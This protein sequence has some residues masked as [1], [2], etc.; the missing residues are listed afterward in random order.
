MALHNVDKN[1]QDRSSPNPNTHDTSYTTG[2]PII[3]V[4]RPAHGIVSANYQPPG[5]NPSDQAALK[6]A[7]KRMV[8]SGTVA[9][10]N[11]GSTVTVTTIAHGLG[12]AP[13]AEG[14]I[15]NASAT[16]IGGLVN[17]PLPTF[18]VAHI[19]AVTPKVDFRVW[20]GA[21]IVDAT[22]VYFQVLNSTGTPITVTVTYYLYQQ[23]AG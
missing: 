11:D 4:P 17:V 5:T 15:N 7:Y 23:V 13:L 12:Y 19:D 9:V 8:Q 21:P 22:N 6:M 20:L 10:I 2:A 14:S 1:S 16:D 18:L 3:N